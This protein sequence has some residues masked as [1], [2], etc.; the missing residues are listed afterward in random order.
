MKIGHLIRK[1]G[2]LAIV[3][4]IT[5]ITSGILGG[6]AGIYLQERQLQVSAVG[7]WMAGVDAGE[8]GD[9]DHALLYL[10]QA[11]GLMHYDPLILQSLAQV[12]EKKGN[13]K[14]ALEFYIKTAEC[15]GTKTSGMSTYIKQKVALLKKEILSDE[16]P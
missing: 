12:Y 3:L 11:T 1:H 6:Y 5:S 7:L 4:L 2:R 10:S 13:K 15:Y 16:K 8:S 9:Y 14:M